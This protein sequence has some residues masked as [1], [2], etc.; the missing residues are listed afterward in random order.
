[1][2]PLTHWVKFLNENIPTQWV[3][4]NAPR[5]K[6]PAGDLFLGVVGSRSTEAD[7]ITIRGVGC[8]DSRHAQSFRGNY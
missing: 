1:M 5:T 3:G 4:C 6:V 2:K 8:K 7:I